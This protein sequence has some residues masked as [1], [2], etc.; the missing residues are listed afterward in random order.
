MKLFNICP[1]F[2][3]CCSN[4]VTLWNFMKICSPYWCIG[5]FQVEGA[6]SWRR[7]LTWRFRTIAL[8]TDA[9]YHATRCNRYVVEARLKVKIDIGFNGFMQCISESSTS[10]LAFWS[11]ILFF[12]MADFSRMHVRNWLSSLSDHSNQTFRRS[13]L[14]LGHSD[15]LIIFQVTKITSSLLVWSNRHKKL[16]KSP[17]H[18]ALHKRNKQKAQR[19]R[20]KSTTTTQNAT[21]EKK[22]GLGIP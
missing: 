19:I 9:Y 13:V 14:E 1:F 5:W 17:N 6:C 12:P 10:I 16:L 21:N 11:F 8:K 3:N 4:S 18:Q 2:C 20:V 22:L 7:A 15:T